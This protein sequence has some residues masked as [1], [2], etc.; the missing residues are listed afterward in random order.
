M[1]L[2]DALLANKA[3]RS[4]TCSERVDDLLL[5]HAVLNK[6]RDFTSDLKTRLGA[7]EEEISKIYRRLTIRLLELVQDE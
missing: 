7:A 5:F 6:H 4:V 1:K 3:P 2:V